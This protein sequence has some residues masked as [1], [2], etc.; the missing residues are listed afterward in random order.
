MSA[1]FRRVNTRYNYNLS[2]PIAVLQRYFEQM[3]DESLAR[4]LATNP[5][6]DQLLDKFRKPN[7][8]RV[9][10]QFFRQ[11][12]RVDAVNEHILDREYQLRLSSTPSVR[13]PVDP[14]NPAYSPTARWLSS[15]DDGMDAT[16]YMLEQAAA[17]RAADQERRRMEEAR[18]QQNV[19]N[20]IL[21]QWWSDED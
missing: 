1:E 6:I 4:C 5:L 19:I 17:I 18:L 16:R 13:V 12:F 9:I 3:D 11:M 15:A 14:T 20:P 8:R 7:N 21:R 10:L 2:Q